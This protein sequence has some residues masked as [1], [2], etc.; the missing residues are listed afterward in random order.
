MCV[1]SI[2]YYLLPAVNATWNVQFSQ[3]FCLPSSDHIKILYQLPI[4]PYSHITIIIITLLSQSTLRLKN[5]L[6]NCR[7]KTHIHET[8]KFNVV[9]VHSTTNSAKQND[10]PVRNRE[11]R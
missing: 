8:Q 10:V 1:I 7:N 6:R 2:N 5:L 9:R 11:K 4:F 3:N